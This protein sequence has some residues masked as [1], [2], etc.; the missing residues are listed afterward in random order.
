MA[1]VKITQ[2]TKDFAQ[3]TKDVLDL[4]KARGVEKKS[5]A[6]LS[7]A[8]FSLFLDALTAENQIENLD[9]YL[10]GKAKILTA[11]AAAEAPAP[12]PEAP[13]PVEE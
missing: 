9:D 3:K 12:A 4:L 6:T 1:A 5:G 8:E 7:E 2:I 13:A 10:S 11:A